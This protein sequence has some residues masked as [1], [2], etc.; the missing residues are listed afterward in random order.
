MMKNNV[1]NNRWQYHWEQM[2]I[3]DEKNNNKK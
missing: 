2:I 3:M 1:N